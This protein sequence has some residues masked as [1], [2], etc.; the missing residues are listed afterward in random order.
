MPRT[1]QIHPVHPT[2]HDI[3]TAVRAV[4]GEA[5]GEGPLGEQAVA[6]VIRNRALLSGESLDQV[7]RTGGFN[8]YDSRARALP[9]NEPAYRTIK[10]NIEG[11]L[12]GV[13]PNP[14][15]PRRTT[16]PPML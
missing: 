2:D 13:A 7:V 15:A 16:T 5:R 3:D 14:R 9:A 11:V 10:A 4:W 12:R 1:L 6:G 8:A